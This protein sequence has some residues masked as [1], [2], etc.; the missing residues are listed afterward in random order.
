[1]QQPIEDTPTRRDSRAGPCE[2]ELLVV[3]APG[4]GGPASFVFETAP[5]ASE[6]A[7]MLRR[8]WP[9]AKLFLAPFSGWAAPTLTAQ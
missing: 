9:G 3:D 7:S 2:V 4:L 1:M 8:I 5:A 6:F